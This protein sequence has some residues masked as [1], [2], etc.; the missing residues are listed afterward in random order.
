M[1]KEEVLRRLQEDNSDVSG[2]D[3]KDESSDEDERGNEGG[4]NGTSQ[5]G[6]RSNGRVKRALNSDTSSSEE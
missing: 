4:E 1:Q 3:K 5:S 2:E 6:Q